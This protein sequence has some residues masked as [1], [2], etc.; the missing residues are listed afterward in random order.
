MI[1]GQLKVR[2]HQT[3]KCSALMG[4]NI[5]ALHN[6]NASGYQGQLCQ[7]YQGTDGV[8]QK[9]RQVELEDIFQCNSWTD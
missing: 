8:G 5:L 3:A 2:E 6:V 9:L 7:D 4:V 1:L